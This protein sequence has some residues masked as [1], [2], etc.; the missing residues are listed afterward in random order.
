MRLVILGAG[1]QLG[2]EL[3]ECAEARAVRAVGLTRAE[4][5]ITDAASIRSAL[6]Q[7]SADAV[8]N[9][10]AWTDVDGAESHAAEAFAINRDGPAALAAECARR[11]LLLVHLSTDYVFN[12]MGT[13]PIA[14]TETP[15]PRS[16]YGSSKLA[17]EEAVREILDTHQIVRTSGLYGRD[18]PN[19]VLK[20]L[21]RAASG[22]ELRVVSD[23]VTSPTWT[24]HLAPAL[25][26]LAERGDPGTY[27]LTNTGS[28][29]WYAL[30]Q[31]ALGSAGIDAPV[32]PIETSDLALAADRPRYSVLDNGAWLRLGEAPL[33]AWDSALRGY[34]D[35]LARRGRLPHA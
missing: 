8:I 6:D 29:T 28:T 4:C 26:R 3:R 33:P 32:T 27:H 12:G 24:A 18:G 13:A 2:S 20:V 11:N 14:E 31:A 9:C 25:L 16:V 30:A 23:Q 17:G 7:H 35:E 1:G 21:R 5:D 22:E 34:I 19:F 15:V 10:A